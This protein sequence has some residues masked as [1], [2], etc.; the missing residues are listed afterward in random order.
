MIRR[1]IDDYTVDDNICVY[2]S[3]G[4]LHRNLL[5]EMRWCFEG[6]HKVARTAFITRSEDVDGQVAEEEQIMCRRC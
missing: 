4:V 6:R 3:D 5:D 2:C 1:D